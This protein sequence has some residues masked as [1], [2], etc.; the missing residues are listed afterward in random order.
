MTSL[1]K[2]QQLSEVHSPI[3]FTYDNET[4][5][6]AAT[7]FVSGDLYKLSVQL[8]NNTIWML[9]SIDPVVWV[10]PVA[11]S[12][13][14]NYK[15][16]WNASTNAPAIVS[17]EGSNG[18]YYIVDVSG[19]TEIDGVS[20]W[21]VGDWIIFNGS[22]WQK[23]DNTSAPTPVVTEVSEETH[24]TS[25]GEEI[26]NVT[27]TAT[28]DCAITIATAHIAQIGKVLEIHNSG[29]ENTISIV[30]EGNENMSGYDD[31][32]MYTQYNV[33]RFRM[34]G[35]YVAEIGSVS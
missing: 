33:V 5:R 10:S 14:L 18:D 25:V 32:Q 2:H 29:G 35:T 12:G 7:G 13:A 19:T 31:Y 26:L 16:V 3:S 21:A 4:N 28:G 9:E 24:L 17:G 6:N 20:T 27:R 15:G 8:D 23:I 34:M 22:E 30:G 11:S 1:H